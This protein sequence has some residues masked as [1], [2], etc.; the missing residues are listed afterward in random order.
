LFFDIIDFDAKRKKLKGKKGNPEQ[1]LEEKKDSKS[2]SMAAG[3]LI[4]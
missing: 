4:N 1:S 2:T 3:Y